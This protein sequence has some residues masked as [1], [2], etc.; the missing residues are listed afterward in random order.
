MHPLASASVPPTATTGGLLEVHAG[1]ILG[2]HLTGGTPSALAWWALAGACLALVVARGRHGRRAAG[3]QEPGME[4]AAGG[5]TQIMAGV[6]AAPAAVVLALVWADHA[7][8]LGLVLAPAGGMVAGWA[9]ALPLASRRGHYV[10]LS[11]A[12]RDAR[13]TT[14]TRWA[15]VAVVTCA[16]TALLASLPD[17]LVA[18][19]AAA[20]AI[21]VAGEGGVVH[22]RTATAA[23]RAG[24]VEQLAA[25]LSVAPSALEAVAWYA[26]PDGGVI[27]ERPPA[28]AIAHLDGLAERCG[29]VWPHLEVAEATATRIAFA[30]ASDAHRASAAEQIRSGGLLAGPSTGPDAGSPFPDAGAAGAGGGGS[31][32]APAPPPVD[33]IDLDDE[34][35][36]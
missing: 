26:T 5:L 6:L 23:Q 24:L 15:A 25:V 7:G 20:V 11:E 31:L 10:P 9:V 32:P 29:R 33:V 4:M 19:V 36:R 12:V 22:R 21:G 2:V 28:Q 34:D 17:G 1:T 27:V 8:I 3:L 13:P 35:L 14:P 18:G 30:S 16:A